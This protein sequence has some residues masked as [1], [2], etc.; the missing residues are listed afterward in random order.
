MRLD[1]AATIYMF[2]FFGQL[3]GDLRCAGPAEVGL[4]K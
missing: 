3:G 2:R 1:G 4:G